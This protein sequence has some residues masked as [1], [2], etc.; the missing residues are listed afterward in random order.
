L[1]LLDYI[2]SVQGRGGGIRLA[3][4]AE[5]ITVGMVFRDMEATLELIDCVTKPC[6][7]LSV[8]KLKG[9]VN[10]ATNEFLSV[11][12]QHTIAEMIEPKE[13]LLNLI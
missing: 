12:D 11:L 7:I 3:I 6:P 4:P 1:A 13:Q 2:E 9:V 8:C 10:K 5:K